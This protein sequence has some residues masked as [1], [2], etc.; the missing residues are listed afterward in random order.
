MKIGSILSISMVVVIFLAILLPAINGIAYS[1]VR[2]R[3][4]SNNATFYYFFHITDLHLGSSSAD[5]GKLEAF[6]SVVKNV[7]T[8]LPV[9][10][11]AVINTG[12]IVDDPKYQYYYDEYGY[13]KA[14]LNLSGTGIVRLD[15]CGNHDMRVYTDSNTGTTYNGVEYFRENFGSPVYTYDIYVN[16]THYVKFIS[17]NTTKVNYDNGYINSTLLDWL[18]QKIQE[19]EDDPNCTGIWVFGHHP[20]APNSSENVTAGGW[21]YKATPFNTIV[22]AGS[23]PWRFIRIVSS[24]AKVKGVVYGHVHENWVTQHYGKY[25]IVTAPLT[26]TGPW[27]S[28]SSRFYTGE[29]YVYRIVSVYNGIVSTLVVPV[30]TMP[31][32]YIVNM[33]Q[34]EVVSGYVEVIAFAVSDVGVSSVELYLD[35]VKVADLQPY[36]ASSKGG[37][38]RGVFDAE[39]ISDWQHYLQIHVIDSNGG[40]Y[41][42]P[43]LYFFARKAGGLRYVRS[44]LG[45]ISFGLRENYP[46]ARLYIYSDASED[47]PFAAIYAPVDSS[48]DNIR[49]KALIDTEHI[50][51]RMRMRFSLVTWRE[52]PSYSDKVWNNA[53]G[54]L[55]LVAGFSTEKNDVYPYDFNAW[56]QKGDP[57][58]WWGD[59]YYITS[60]WPAIGYWGQITYNSTGFKVELWPEN[61][62]YGGP[63][64][65]SYSWSYYNTDYDY[66]NIKYAGILVRSDSTYYSQVAIAYL[67][68]GD[69]KGLRKYNM[70]PNILGIPTKASIDS[71][72]CDSLFCSITFSIESNTTE[73]LSGKAVVEGSNDNTT[74]FELGEV[75]VNTTSSVFQYTVDNIPRYQAYRIVFKP[76]YNL[77]HLYATTASSP[78]PAVSPPAPI[79]EEITI[80]IAVAIISSITILVA[81]RL[82]KQYTKY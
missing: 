47:F 67:E 27:P 62:T 39:S 68:I 52:E 70:V 61:E 73:G 28:S 41:W 19:A 72:E 14:T 45:M 36:N 42:S 25:W 31:I 9:K 13:Y 20:P 64:T 59:Y 55:K 74:W 7:Y 54:M 66:D 65:Y 69:S 79:P 82:Y 75:N 26:L 2:V 1:L 57:N 22:A 10:P 63:H 35:G 21:D 8:D 6:A 40:D 46:V 34:G 81:L 44:D 49:V 78:A 51:Y 58:E 50:P 43:K 71:V 15:T 29:G 11:L 38:Y 30:G 60:W 16:S 77:V 33:R 23:D 3:V 4:N 48:G 24:Y 76:S 18:E 56:R 53:Q 5:T 17:L 12:D 32:G 80:I 37:L